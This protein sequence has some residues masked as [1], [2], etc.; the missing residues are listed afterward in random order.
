MINSDTNVK[1]FPKLISLANVPLMTHTS[2]PPT[3]PPHPSPPHPH[4]GRQYQCQQHEGI[5]ARRTQKTQQAI[6]STALVTD[7]QGLSSLLIILSL[8]VSCFQ[9]MVYGSR[10]DASDK[11]PRPPPS[12]PPTTKIKSERDLE[13]IK[14]SGICLLSLV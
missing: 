12:P 1:F 4:H 6:I 3:P 2:S 13:S 11:P 5:D 8:L 14:D 10:K 7:L 9:S